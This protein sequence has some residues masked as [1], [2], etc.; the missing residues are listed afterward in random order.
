MNARAAGLLGESQRIAAGPEFGGGSREYHGA[1]IPVPRI[2]VDFRD[3]WGGQDVDE[4]Y[5]RKVYAGRQQCEDCGRR[6]LGGPMLLERERATIGKVHT[7]LC[8]ACIE[9]RLGRRLTQDN[10]LVSRLNAGWIEYNP[11]DPTARL[12]ALGRHLLPV[13]PSPPAN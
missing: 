6:S 5:R 12:F 11:A 4:I 3:M 13:Y 9:Q 10:L 1:A 7:F 2:T 8:F